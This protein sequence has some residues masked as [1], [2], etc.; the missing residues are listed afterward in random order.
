MGAPGI[1][2]GQIKLA[3]SVV[4]CLLTH[5]CLGGRR[6]ESWKPTRLGADSGTE[7]GVGGRWAWVLLALLKSSLSIGGHLVT[8]IIY[9]LHKLPCHISV[10]KSV[11]IGK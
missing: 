4:Q 1:G 7:D 3:G 2:N 9:I 6:I 5:Y 8:F 10:F 11:F